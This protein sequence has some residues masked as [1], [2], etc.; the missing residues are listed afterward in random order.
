MGNE[1]LTACLAGA[2]E[3]ARCDALT[4]SDNDPFGRDHAAA[5]ERQHD[6]GMTSSFGPFAQLGCQPRG[7]AAKPEGVPL[8][9]EVLEIDTV[10]LGVPVDPYVNKAR[11]PLEEFREEC[12]PR[13][14]GPQKE[15]DVLR[16][17]G[18]D[19]FPGAEAR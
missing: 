6:A 15:D 14:R 19:R 16:P 11:G 12:L 5:R 3:Q 10:A 4:L 9:P 2:E 13:P 18:H 8:R 1:C 7:I 17:F